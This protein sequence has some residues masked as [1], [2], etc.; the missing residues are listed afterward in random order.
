MKEPLIVVEQLIGDPSTPDAVWDSETG[1]VQPLTPSDDIRL[2]KRCG[3]RKPVDEFRRRIS[4]NKA[5]SLARASAA[6]RG[7]STEPI[8]AEAYHRTMTSVHSMCNACAIKRRTR[9]NVKNTA[10]IKAIQTKHTTTVKQ[11]SVEEY[12]T[13]LQL[14]GRYE[15]Q[16]PNP[17]GAEP[18]YIMLREAMVEEYRR[19]LNARRAEAT[20]KAKKVSAVPAYKVFTKDIYNEM[21]RIKMMLKTKRCADSEILREFCEA[22]LRH[23]D[24]TREIIRKERYAATPVKPKANVFKY[25]DYTSNVTRNAMT[26]LRNLSSL[27]LERAKPKFLPTA[28]LYD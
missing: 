6:R 24:G 5:L 19:T 7:M 4:I 13:E 15:H 17:Y 14:D 22:Y 23:L 11:L 21:Q 25:I 3:L 8:K 18:R 16:T 2:C 12:D 26:Q 9:A 20:R 1:K 27:D 10:L 28:D